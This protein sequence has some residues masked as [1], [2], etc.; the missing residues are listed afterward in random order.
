MSTEFCEK[1]TV[2]SLLPMQTHTNEIFI[3]NIHYRLQC[4]IWYLGLNYGK[5]LSLYGTYQYMY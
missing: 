1:F 2:R 4:K 5:T 3:F